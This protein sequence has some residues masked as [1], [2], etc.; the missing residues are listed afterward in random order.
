M[1]E[2][3]PP[4]LPGGLEDAMD[5]EFMKP[6]INVLLTLSVIIILTA[7]GCDPRPR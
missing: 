2:G 7:L 1:T 6:Q 4:E 5:S 3:A